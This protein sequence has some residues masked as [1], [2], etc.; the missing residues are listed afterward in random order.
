ME[1][2]LNDLKAEVGSCTKCNVPAHIF[3]PSCKTKLCEQLDFT[4]M[5]CFNI[6]HTKEGHEIFQR[7][8]TSNN[9]LR[10]AYQVC[11]THPI[12]QRVQ[13]RLG[14]ERTQKKKEPT[15]KSAINDGQERDSNLLALIVRT[16]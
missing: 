10:S 15:T 14:I 9:K 5:T 3:E 13:E 12:I 4:N 1:E 7:A 2:E 16:K 6:M 11:D 8:Q